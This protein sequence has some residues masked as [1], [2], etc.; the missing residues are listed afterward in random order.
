MRPVSELLESRALTGTPREHDLASYPASAAD[1]PPTRKRVLVLAYS[2]SGQLTAITESLI[3]PLRADARIEV[4]VETLKPQRAFPF[5]WSLWR[6]LDAFPE[7]A[8]LVP[9][10]IDTPRLAPDDAFDLV[11]LP[12]Q[13]WFLAPSQPVTAFL[14]HP[15]ARQVLAGKPV[16]S[17]IACRNMWMMAFEKMKGLLTDSGARLID[18]VVLTD[19]AP[20]LAT[21][22]STPMWMLT[23]RRD[24]VPGLPPA[25]VSADDIRRCSRFGRALRD[26]LLDGRET[27]NAPLLSGLRAV[28][29]APK[30]LASE[31]AGTRSFLVWGH[32]LR[33]AGQPGS[34]RRIPLLIL[35]LLFLILMILTVVPTSLTVQA[36]LRRRMASRLAGHKAYFEQPSG[37][38]SERLAQY[39]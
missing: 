23:G 25:G 34:P 20:T 11:I 16:V 19:R 24:A 9:T 35:Y 7:S 12:W 33:A 1:T 10:A 28:E 31:R 36:L 13:V 32:L 5:P 6:F 14:K 27:G 39:D 3:A 8:H 29:A 15:L 2:Q 18:N 17:V 22:I 30:L 37:S 21:L 26:A 4:H 38:G